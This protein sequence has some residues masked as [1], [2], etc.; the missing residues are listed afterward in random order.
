MLSFKAMMLSCLFLQAEVLD[1]ANRRRGDERF[2]AAL[3]T[4]TPLEA[5]LHA[6]ITYTY[7]EGCVAAG[8]WH[9]NVVKRC[10]GSARRSLT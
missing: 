1:A 9:S 5:L 2:L 10:C 7:T 6:D 3:S 8:F 4:A